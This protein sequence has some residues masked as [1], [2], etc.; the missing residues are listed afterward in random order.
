MIRTDHP[1]GILGLAGK[2]VR[3]ASDSKF[4]R[5]VRRFLPSVTVA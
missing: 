5:A 1:G 2:A 3:V 4:K